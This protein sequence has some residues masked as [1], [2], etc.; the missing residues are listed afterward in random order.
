MLCVSPA[1]RRTASTG[2]SRATALA[3]LGP[4]ASN[5]RGRQCHTGVLSSSDDPALHL[6]REPKGLLLTDLAGPTHTAL[7]TT[8]LCCDRNVRLNV[9]LEEAIHLHERTCRSCGRQWTFATQLSPLSGARWG[10]SIFFKEGRPTVPAVSEVLDG[11]EDGWIS[12]SRWERNRYEPL[13][14]QK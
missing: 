1:R 2:H 11:R 7:N 13:Y 3:A 12:D 4:T 6:P 9:P 5:S 10:A 8:T 14:Q